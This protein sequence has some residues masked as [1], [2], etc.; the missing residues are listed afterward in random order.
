MT[1]PALVVRPAA[2]PEAESHSWSPISTVV[3]YVLGQP[4]SSFEVTD[5]LGYPV[6]TWRTSCRRAGVIFRSLWIKGERRFW[7]VKPETCGA[8]RKEDEVA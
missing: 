6:N 4:E 3:Q 1:D 7:I 8:R 2:V 5:L